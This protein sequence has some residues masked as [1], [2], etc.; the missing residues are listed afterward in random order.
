MSASS[1]DRLNRSG[2]SVSSPARAA[3]AVTP[4]NT[5]ALPRLPK[6]L[7]IGIGGTL[8]LRAVDAVSDVTVTVVAGQIVPIRASHVRATGTSAAQ[9]VGLA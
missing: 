8:T 5:E 9:I 2:D 4:H 6:A 3:F 7:M 1:F